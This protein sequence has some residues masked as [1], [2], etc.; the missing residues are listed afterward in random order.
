MD[1]AWILADPVSPVLKPDDVGALIGRDAD[2]VRVNAKAGRAP[3]IRLGKTLFRIYR[4]DVPAWEKLDQRFRRQGKPLKA[5][6]LE[7]LADR[8]VVYFIQAETGGPIKIG[9]AIDAEKRMASL[10]LSCPVKLRLLSKRPGG[11]RLERFLHRQF[12]AYRLHG[13]WFEPD[14]PGLRREIRTRKVPSYER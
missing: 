13:E 6:H 8:G 1:R 10:Q 14:A 3:A 11:E 12:A 9:T 7:L 4:S 2:W 5:D